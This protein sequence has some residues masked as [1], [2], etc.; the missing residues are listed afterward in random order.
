LLSKEAFAEWLDNPATLEILAA[1]RIRAQLLAK[2]TLTHVWAS[3]FLT[4]DQ[5]VELAKIKGKVQ[6]LEDLASWTPEDFDVV[7]LEKER[8]PTGW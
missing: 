3:G 1:L 4:S 7:S 8:D 5:Q 2:T 6:M